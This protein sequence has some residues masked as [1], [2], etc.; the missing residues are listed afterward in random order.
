MIRQIKVMFKIGLNNRTNGGNGNQ[1]DEAA[2]K[3]LNF[4]LKQ[5]NELFGQPVKDEY[6]HLVQWFIKYEEEK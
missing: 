4:W 5:G 3:D 6:G 2:I 1:L